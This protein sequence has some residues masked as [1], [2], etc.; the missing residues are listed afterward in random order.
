MTTLRLGVIGYGY[1]G[2]NLVRNFAT[3]SRT[4]VAAIAEPQASRR[5]AAAMNHPSIP[6]VEDAAA[7]F[8][9]PEI[10]A[11]V[12]ATPIYTH[13]PLAA[14]AL[15][16]GKH[17]LVEKPLTSSVAEAEELAVLAA[18][19][20]RVLMVDHTFVYTSA[21]RKIRDLV[22][23]GELGRVLY[24][25]SVRINL[26]L[27]QP[28]VN[29]IWDLAPHDLT[30]MDFVISQTLGIAAR[31]ISAIGV[32]HY[33][34]QENLAYLTVGFDDGLL[35]HF[36]VNWVAPVKTRRTI[37][38]G[39]KRMLVW[40][41]TSPVEPVK[42]YESSVD[43]EHIDKESAYAL[44]VQYRSGDIRSPKLD[45]KEALSVMAQAFA[46][47]CLDGTPTPSDGAVGVRIVRM[48]EAAQRSLEQHGTR[49]A[50]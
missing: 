43:V 17:V 48:L 12:I 15:A 32:A 2:P 50:L 1:W 29:V 13:H 33:G 24:L 18:R 23:A 46:G 21:V 16:A 30:I 8:A 37:I 22:A 26:G 4:R 31:W 42:I 5:Q 34:H 11:I 39:S 7:L 45:G 28:D 27:F 19:A 10:D 25:D 14:A 44:N 47:A 36:H 38:A 35:A 6:T 20:G 49:V 9:N 3:S 40:D 41:D